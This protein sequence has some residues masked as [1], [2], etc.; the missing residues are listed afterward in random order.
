MSAA[1]GA[2]L[3]LLGAAGQ[4]DDRARVSRLL[5]DAGLLVQQYAGV[6]AEPLVS[7]PGRETVLEAAE[8][9]GLLVVGLSDRWREE[10][11]SE[12]RAEIAKSAPATT[13]FV[14]RGERA[15]ALAPRDDMT[16]FRWSAANIAAPGPAPGP[17]PAE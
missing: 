17:A 16:R 9:A 14:R 5:G 11:L 8:A 2:P 15:G 7:E 3:R 4:T 12:L 1:T 6:A 10:G 13:L